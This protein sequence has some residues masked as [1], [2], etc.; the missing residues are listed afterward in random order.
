MI[1]VHLCT[2][3]S[4]QLHLGCIFKSCI[5]MVCK[6]AH[7]KIVATFPALHPAPT[8]RK[9]KPLKPLTQEPYALKQEIF[10]STLL[11]QRC[12]AMKMSK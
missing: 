9:L 3:V 6:Y 12:F 11:T 7:S 5:D 2:A 4:Q 10:Q 8:E 1:Y